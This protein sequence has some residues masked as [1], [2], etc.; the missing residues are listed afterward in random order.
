MRDI[1]KLR[2]NWYWQAKDKLDQSTLWCFSFDGSCDFVNTKEHS[3]NC[4]LRRAMREN[5]AYKDYGRER[6]NAADSAGEET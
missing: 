6:D 3:A 2:F 4:T 1:K 5:E